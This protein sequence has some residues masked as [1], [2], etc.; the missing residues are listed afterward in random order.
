MNADRREAIREAA[1]EARRRA[2]LLAEEVLALRAKG[3]ERLVAAEALVAS[4][5]L[6]LD[7]LRQSVANH[8]ELMRLLGESV[9]RVILDV[10]EVADEATHSVRAKNPFADR[11]KA[12]ELREYLVRWTIDAYYGAA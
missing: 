11:K 10:K 8:A 6:V 1:R 9:E 12:R 7:D 5:N 4:S 3:E 2:R